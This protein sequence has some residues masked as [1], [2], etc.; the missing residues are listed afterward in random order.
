MSFCTTC[1]DGRDH[2]SARLLQLHL[3]ETHNPFR[4][5]DSFPCAARGCLRTFPNKDQ[6]ERHCVREHGFPRE[7]ALFKPPQGKVRVQHTHAPRPA[8]V[9][10]EPAGFTGRRRM[11]RSSASSSSSSSSPRAGKHTSVRVGIAPTASEPKASQTLSFV[12]RSVAISR[13]KRW[14]IAFHYFHSSCK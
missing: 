12:P 9:H 2:L 5:S 3:D 7:I 1:S 6:R 8:S 13:S 14:I 10:A 4:S 11:S